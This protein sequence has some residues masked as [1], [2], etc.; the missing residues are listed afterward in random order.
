M[1]ASYEGTAKHAPAVEAKRRLYQDGRFLRV[2]YETFRQ[3]PLAGLPLSEVG[4]PALVVSATKDS[5]VSAASA[6]AIADALGE[7]ASIKSLR[8]TH[9]IPFTR[10]KT[11]G[12]VLADFF[13]A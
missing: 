7:K 4:M 9:A 2:L 6:R 1:K 3:F 5:V 11:V 12:R 8:G 10:P 13:D